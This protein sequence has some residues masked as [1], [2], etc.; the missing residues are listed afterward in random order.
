MIESMLVIA[1]FKPVPLFSRTFL[2]SAYVILK[3][4]ILVSGLIKRMAAI[5]DCLESQNT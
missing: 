1:V 5:G 3:V 2:L 4:I